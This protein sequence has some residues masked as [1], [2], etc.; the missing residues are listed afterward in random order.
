[1]VEKKCGSG[2]YWYDTTNT[3]FRC[4]N[5]V[6][7]KKC[8]TG[9]YDYSKENNTW[10][11]QN[12]VV[13][14]ACGSNWYDTTNANFRCQNNVVETRCGSGNWYDAYNSSLRCQND[15]VKKKCDIYWNDIDRENDTWRCQN[16]SLQ[17]M[18]DTWYNVATNY[19]STDYVSTR[20]GSLTDSRD[21]KTYK[22]FIID[23]QIWMAENLNFV[24]SDSKCYSNSETN[25]NTY[26]RLYDWYEAKTV[27]PSGW[28][29]P[30]SDELIN[31]MYY[32]TDDD[33][34][35]ALLLGGSYTN[36]FSNKDKAGFWWSITPGDVTSEAYSQKISFEEEIYSI[37]EVSLSKSN[38]LSVRCIK[39]E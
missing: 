24:T 5:N 12:D 36:S 21:Y 2:N 7:E 39:N 11:C 9:W 3:N 34:N 4:Q 29:S 32:I 31:L 10:K 6:V 27:C 1:V 13:L 14:K 16:G 15:V 19:C 30:E 23:D 8:N 20:Y 37:E 28:H 26:G 17:K 22:T 38:L 33:Y 25:C 35:F 18:C